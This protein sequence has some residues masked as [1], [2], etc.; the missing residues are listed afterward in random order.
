[1]T[2]QPPTRD[3]TVE[4]TTS[5]TTWRFD[6]AFLTSNWQCIWGR[7]C[8]GILAEPSEHL[9]QGC[10]SVGAEL[11]GVDEAMNLAAL[12]ASIT[13]V[14]WQFRSAAED[15]GIFRTP[16]R[17]S[18]RIVDGACIFLNRPG[19]ASGAG[20]ALHLAALD[21]G[22]SPIDW[23]PSVC[24][25]LPIKVD[26]ADRGDGGEIATVRRWTRADWGDDEEEMAWWCTEANEAYSA[27]RPV[28]ETLGDELC[29]I[30][31]EAVYVE[32]RK[33]LTTATAPVAVT[34]EQFQPQR[35]NDLV[36][37]GRRASGRV[38]AG[39]PSQSARTH[40]ITG[41]SSGLGLASA[42]VLAASG[43]HVVMACRNQ[44]KGDAARARIATAVPGARLTVLPLDLASLAST[45]R[46]AAILNAAVDRVDVLMN[47]AGVM[48][49]DYGR[50][51]DGFEMQF[52]TNHLGHFALTGLI[53]PLLRQN[54][55]GARIVTV[56][57]LGHRVGRVDLDDPHFERRRYERWGAYFQS[58]L[59]NL[60]FSSELARR[61]RTDNVSVSSLAA[62][63]GTAATELG[64]TGSAT[65][66][67]IVRNCFGAIIRGAEAGARSQVCAAVD[68]SIPAG[69]LVGPSML[70][71]GSPRLETPSRR[72]RDAHLAT[73]LWG[74]SEQQTG[75]TYL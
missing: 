27:T 29:H 25:Q 68:Q 24:W 63:P 33:R 4:I 47:N 30:V 17:T 41:A 43:A 19:F 69:S 73:A 9:A 57:S 1:M 58:K 55:D 72:A 26:W 67:W 12:A 11:D 46:F 54:P 51:A 45:Q 42:T 14:L 34:H 6:R 10:C 56:S 64:K 53:L 66:N 75:V 21:C 70:A 59:A 31:G 35:C 60:L 7:G 61:L 48:A 74:L 5:D 52:G 36:L 32:I 37:M 62:H 16:E 18:T 40:V 65:S 8:Q 44:A 15:G 23:K 38:A 50:T 20:C 71:F 49:V 13:D 28:I 39:L 2:N 22:E 3:D